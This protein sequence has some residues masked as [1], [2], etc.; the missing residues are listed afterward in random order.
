[1]TVRAGVPLTTTLRDEGWDDADIAQMYEDAETER[2]QQATYA[3]A[4]LDQAQRQ[5]DAGSVAA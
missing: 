5:F 1:L 2:T 3:A 4:V